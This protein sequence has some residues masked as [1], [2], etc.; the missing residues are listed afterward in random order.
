MNGGPDGRMH[1]LVTHGQHP[2]ALIITG[3]SPYVAPENVFGIEPGDSFVHRR[4][5]GNY[6]HEHTPGGLAATIEF[7]VVAKKI[8]SLIIVG[9][10]NDVNR[11]YAE[12]RMDRYDLVRSFMEKATPELRQWRESGMHPD[13]MHE[14]SL[15]S[16]YFNT[17]RHPAVMD[18]MKNSKLSVAALFVDHEQQNM[19][20]YNPVMDKFVQVTPPSY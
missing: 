2:Q 11:D 5:G 15:R 20:F 7:A 17:M 8:K 14:N 18:A 6:H 10:R 19:E 4:I 3:I 13:R 1:D 9:H 16:T 12:G